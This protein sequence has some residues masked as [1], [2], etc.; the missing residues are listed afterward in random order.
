MVGILPDKLS[1]VCYANASSNKG[2]GHVMRCIAVS[3]GFQ[4]VSDNQIDITFCF[5]YCADSL[6]MKLRTLGYTCVQLNNSPWAEIKHLVPDILLVDDYDLNPQDWQEI[7]EIDAYKIALDD[8]VAEHYLPVQMIVNPASSVSSLDYH[9]RCQP[10]TELCLGPQ[11]AYL[12]EEFSQQESL[13]LEQRQRLLITMGGSDLKKIGGLLASTLATLLPEVQIRW[14]MGN[15]NQ[16][17]ESERAHYANFENLHCIGVCDNMAAEINQAGLAISAAGGT[18]GE[19]AC[20]ATP[21]LALV[22]IDNQHAALSARRERQV[23]WFEVYDLRSFE[24]YQQTQTGDQEIVKK[25]NEIC[26]DA[27]NLWHDQKRRSDMS[28]IAS[29]LVDSLGC[30]RIAQR[31]LRTIQ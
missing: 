13:V 16:Y 3:Q 5:Q 6:Q 18:L 30:Q 23:H 14:L 17:A 9:K 25:I 21:C 24:A 10:S 4:A 11:Y 15:V 29:R 7:G 2:A 8:N 12:R 28:K 1:L 22:C 27:V 31:A 26:H 19:L 20:L